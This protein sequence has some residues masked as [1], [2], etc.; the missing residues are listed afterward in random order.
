[1]SVSI[2]SRYV[3]NIILSISFSLTAFAIDD[4]TMGPILQAWHIDAKPGGTYGLILSF[5][6]GFH[7]VLDFLVLSY[8][9]R[10]IYLE[11]FI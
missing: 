10:S 9:V 8:V 1:M 4:F 5:C 11:P 3:S 6:L 2:D 7:Y